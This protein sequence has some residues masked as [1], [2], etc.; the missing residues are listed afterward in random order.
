MRPRETIGRKR[1]GMLSDS[2]VLL[3]GNTHAIRKTQELLKKFRWKVWSHPRTAQIWHPIW[4]PNTYLEQGSLQTA[5]WKKLPRTSSMGRDVI[6]TKP[7]ETSWS[8]DQR[9]T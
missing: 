2:V 4:V 5:M 1:P 7:G 9:K 3:D 6:S 8:C